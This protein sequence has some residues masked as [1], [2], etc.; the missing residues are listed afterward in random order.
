MGS[1]TDLS[2]SAGSLQPAKPR[3]L[4]VPARLRKSCK[5]AGAARDFLGWKSGRSGGSGLSGAGRRLQAVHHATPRPAPPP[6]RAREDVPRSVQ[7]GE[8]GTAA[9]G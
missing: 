4:S 5:A 8:V 2:A 7:V 9:A 3:C 1:D 6:L